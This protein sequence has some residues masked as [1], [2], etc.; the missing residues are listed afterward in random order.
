MTA[1]RAY[2]IG[3]IQ[4]IVEDRDELMQ[5]AEALAGEIK[6]CA[7]LA[8]Q[9]I[10]QVIRIQHNMPT[11]PTG[12]KRLDYAKELTKERQIQLSNSEDNKEGPLAFAEK[13]P[14]VWKGR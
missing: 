9:Y 3:Y 14:P 7:P 6:L 1:E 11:P 13:R 4:Q 8:T 10:K 2:Q 5:A 12:V